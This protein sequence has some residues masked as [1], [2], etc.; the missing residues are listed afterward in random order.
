MTDDR[1]LPIDPIEDP[2]LDEL[3]SSAGQVP[4]PAD[5]EDRVIRSVQLPLPPWAHKLKRLRGSLVGTPLGRLGLAG[6]ALGCVTSVTFVARWTGAHFSTVQDGFAWL[7]ANVGLA[8]WQS[9]LRL[10]SNYFSAML[11]TIAPGIGPVPFTVGAGLV[12]L[13][14]AVGLYITAGPRA[15][16]NRHD[17]L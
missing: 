12:V 3:I 1:N 17:A 13:I 8:T 6:M 14:S 11:S 16:R 7:G 9:T 2:A 10:A 5:F 4:P 15:V